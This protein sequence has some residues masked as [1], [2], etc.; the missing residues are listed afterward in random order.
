[1]TGLLM[2]TALCDSSLKSMLDYLLLKADP[3]A[4]EAAALLEDEAD[5]S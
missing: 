3:S 4:L 1:M 2:P 5:K